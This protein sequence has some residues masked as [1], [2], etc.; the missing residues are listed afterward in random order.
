MCWFVFFDPRI[1]AHLDSVLV[2]VFTALCVTAQL[3]RILVLDFCRF[4]AHSIAFFVF[5]QLHGVF[6]GLGVHVVVRCYLIILCIGSRFF[7]IS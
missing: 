7:V 2:L 5:V 6:S 1:A 4:S 3:S